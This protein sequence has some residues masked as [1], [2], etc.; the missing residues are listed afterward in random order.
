MMATL[1]PSSHSTSPTHWAHRTVQL[2][3]VNRAGPCLE[4]T[5]PFGLRARNGR[6]RAPRYGWIVAEVPGV[7]WRG[8]R[9]I[10]ASI[11]AHS[12]GIS[13]LY[14]IPFL[15]LCNKD[16]LRELEIGMPLSC[17]FNL[18]R[19]FCDF[20]VSLTTQ[21]LLETKTSSPSDWPTR[22]AASGRSAALGRPKLLRCACA[23]AVASPCHLH[24]WQ[25]EDLSLPIFG[26]DSG[27]G[28]EG[29]FNGGNC[30]RLW[31]DLVE[32]S[33][34]LWRGNK[35]G[36]RDL[37]LRFCNKNF[38]PTKCIVF[39]SSEHALFFPSRV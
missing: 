17:L 14:M 13:P 3:S 23:S 20:G 39:Q 2:R 16:A 7:F 15:L 19:P 31:L 26:A 11:F 35:I 1:V 10:S 32:L 29:F 9:S 12:T 38:N 24:S 33:L 22:H 34:K 37:E 6:Q 18:P 8:N 21:T 25:H 36:Y 27:A 5:V 28:P 4:T 30:P